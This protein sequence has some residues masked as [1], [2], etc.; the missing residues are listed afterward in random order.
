MHVLV[1][2]DEP[3]VGDTVARMIRM[4]GNS[5]STALTGDDALT[6]MRAE[7]PAIVLLDLKLGPNSIAGS[8]V[9]QRKILDPAIRSIPVIIFT[10]LLEAADPADDIVETIQ[11]ALAGTTIV[12]GK[13][14]T[15][16]ILRTALALLDEGSSCEHAHGGAAA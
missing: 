11:N 6:L 13:P 8:E 12:L 1:V 7:R 14:L 3:M 16:P 4:L 9:W 5:C 2:D 10:G 15:L